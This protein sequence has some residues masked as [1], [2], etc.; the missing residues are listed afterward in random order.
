MSI[1]QLGYLGFRVSRIAA[2]EV[3]LGQGLGLMPGQSS[4][5]GPR[6]R[7]DDLAWRI[8][9]EPGSEDDLSY[10]GFEVTGADA[11]DTMRRRLVEAGVDIGN[12]DP[13]LRQERGVMD[14]ITCHDPNGLRVEIFYGPTLRREIP[15]V[16]PVGT[17]GFV[18]GD[19]GLGHIVLIS[20][21]V[22][23]LRRFY[24]DVLGFRLSDIIR[25]Q[26]APESALQAEFYH[27]N[28]RHHTLALVGA[29]SSKRLHHF[30]LQVPG[31]DAVGL[32]LD[33]M[34]TVDAPITQSLGRHTNDQMVSFY[35]ETPSGFEV[36]LGCGAIDVDDATWRVSRHDRTSIWGHRRLVPHG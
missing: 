4:T 26:V 9:L 21:N 13:A 16:S 14:L 30:L 17:G 2:W 36:E 32:A 10:V 24:I 6:F 19:Q 20:E 29:R 5:L 34:A 8:A 15:F 28:S 33:R 18:T 22:D 23:A 12:D 35:V 11:L 31:L 25:M 27:C 1:G 7:A 3:F